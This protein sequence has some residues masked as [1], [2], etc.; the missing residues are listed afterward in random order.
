[1]GSRAYTVPENLC[2]YPD[3]AT[4]SFKLM[5]RYSSDVQLAANRNVVV[6][7]GHQN[8]FFDRTLVRANSKGK[9]NQVASEQLFRR[10]KRL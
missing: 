5:T 2:A 10:A 8:S 1:M 3:P 4:E 6:H 7:Y 9:E